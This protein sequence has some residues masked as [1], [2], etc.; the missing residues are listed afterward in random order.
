[1]VEL[2]LKSVIGRPVFSK[3]SR[4]RIKPLSVLH[5]QAHRLPRD[6]RRGLVRAASRA[7]VV[8]AS[9]VEALRNSQSAGGPS[10]IPRNS[11]FKYSGV[12]PT[13]I[14]VRPRDRF[15]PSRLRGVDVLGHTERFVRFDD[16]DQVMRHGG[17]LGASRLGGA[18]VHAADR[19]PS[20]RAK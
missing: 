5:M 2:L 14:G 20:S 8:A 19:R 15:R 13:K 6:R 18:D 17:L 16:I 1:M 7:R 3:T 4:T 10:K 12:P 11:A 9:A